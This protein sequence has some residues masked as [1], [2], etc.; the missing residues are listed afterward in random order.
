[1]I[2]EDFTVSEMVAADCVLLLSEVTVTTQIGLPKCDSGHEGKY[3]KDGKDHF[4]DYPGWEKQN[5]KGHLYA[6]FSDLFEGNHD[7]TGDGVNDFVF[8]TAHQGPGVCEYDP[9]ADNKTFGYVYT[10]NDDTSA[11]Q[12]S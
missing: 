1:M 8:T 3:Y 5:D 9:I 11:I 6:L 10:C 7:V 4:Y 12:K 2:V